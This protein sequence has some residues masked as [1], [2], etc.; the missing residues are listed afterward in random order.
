MILV[1]HSHGHSDHTARDNQFKGQDNVVMV[2]AVLKVVVKHYGLK[3]WPM[4]EVIVDLG[5]RQLTIFPIPDHQDASITVYAPQTQ[6]LLTGDTF[7]PG[8]LYVREWAEYKI[9]IQKLVDFTRT[10][11]VTALMGTHIEISNIPGD[12][13]AL[14]LDHQPNEASCRSRQMI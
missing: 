6:W 13:F 11:P 1:T 9:S 14:G 4:G 12:I 2:G 5:G 7:F 10:H 8:R 3:E